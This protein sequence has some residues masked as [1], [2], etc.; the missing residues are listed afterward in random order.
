MFLILSGEF[1][2][3]KKIGVSH[4]TGAFYDRA[5][6]ALNASPTKRKPY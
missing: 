4:S 5:A 2:L 6:T 1:K 3:T